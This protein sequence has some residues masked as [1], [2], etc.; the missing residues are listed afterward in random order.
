MQVGPPTASPL[1]GGTA[2]ITRMGI[3]RPETPGTDHSPFSRWDLQEP[4]A[5][6]IYFPSQNRHCG[7]K[8]KL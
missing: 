5:S 8:E 7:M 1:E 2:R 4:Q 3:D 6:S